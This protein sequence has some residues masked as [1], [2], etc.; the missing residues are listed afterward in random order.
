MSTERYGAFWDPTPLLLHLAETPFENLV[1]DVHRLRLQAILVS[2]I[3]CLYRSSD[4]ANLQRTVSIFFGGVNQTL[5]G[6]IQ[7]YGKHTDEPIGLDPHAGAG[8]E[9]GRTAAATHGRADRR[10]RTASYGSRA[11]NYAF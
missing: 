9:P 11:A 5:S 6:C 3:L 2:R 8:L 4:L 1:H 7:P 10:V